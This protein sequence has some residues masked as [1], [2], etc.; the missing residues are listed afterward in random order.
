[1]SKLLT[2]LTQTD[3]YIL[4]AIGIAWAGAPAI[5]H[6]GSRLASARLAA[7]R[8]ESYRLRHLTGQCGIHHHHGH[9]PCADG[10]AFVEGG[11][12]AVAWVFSLNP[13]GNPQ[14]RDVVLLSREWTSGVRSYVLA[15]VWSIAS[16]GR[17]RIG[18]FRADSRA[19]LDRQFQDCEIVAAVDLRKGYACVEGVASSIELQNRDELEAEP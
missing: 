6:A 5:I 1:M 3:A 2:T 16:T 12:Q 17:M 7:E 14:R 13:G 8:F 11:D 4:A 9:P 18:R 10:Y 19:L 15:E